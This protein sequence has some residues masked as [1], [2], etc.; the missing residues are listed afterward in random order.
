MIKVCKMTSAS[1]DS[2]SR[3]TPLIEMS[4]IWIPAN[5][6]LRSRTAM[7]SSYE[8]KNSASKTS[9]PKFGFFV[10]KFDDP[11]YKNAEISSNWNSNFTFDALVRTGGGT[12]C[13]STL[14]NC[15]PDGVSVIVRDS[16][17]VSWAGST[18]TAL[19]IGF[20]G[21]APSAKFSFKIFISIP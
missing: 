2:S 15:L 6:F 20:T 14:T 18:M 17:V 8:L 13:V 21:V 19:G 7:P 11:L 16:S 9:V 4:V 12:P 3:I 5:A 10:T 1:I